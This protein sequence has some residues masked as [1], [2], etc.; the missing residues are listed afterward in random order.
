MAT[1]YPIPTLSEAGSL[2][3]GITFVDN[4]NGTATLAG[5]P[6]AGTEGVYNLTF[7]AI[8]NVGSGLASQSFTL[9][10]NQIT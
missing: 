7:R 8:N 3:S 10:V 1:G 6:T 4:G 5:T 2:P 9:T